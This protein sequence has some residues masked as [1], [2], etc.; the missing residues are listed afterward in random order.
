MKIEIEEGQRKAFYDGW[1][2]IAIALLVVSIPAPA[3]FEQ[4]AF[5][6][7]LRFLALPLILLLLH[8]DGV[9]LRFRPSWNIVFCLPAF[10]FCF[11]NLASLPFS[12]S[13]VNEVGDLTRPILFTLGTALL[14]EVV[15]RFAFIEA[16]DRT[17]LKKYDVWISAVVFGLCH[18]A[19]ILAGAA[20]LP[21]LAQAGYTLLLGLVLG[22]LY[23]VG[24]IFPCI[25]LH[26]AF[27]FFQN[28]LYLALGG[29]TWNLPFFAFNIGF[30]LLSAG[31]AFFLYWKKGRA[32]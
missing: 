32:K 9:E 25:L 3:L 4:E 24:G 21:T 19:S 13:A 17:N 8:H 18:L 14:E 2:A 28:D 27:N 31:Y 11:G 10:L 7:V 20:I 1:I 16:I 26:F 23:K 22:F 6:G 5:T 15:F 30:Y 12:G 29:G